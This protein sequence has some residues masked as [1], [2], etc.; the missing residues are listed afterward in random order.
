M[1]PRIPITAQID[2]SL[3]KDIF[4]KN[5]GNNNI[6]KGVTREIIPIT[7]ERATLPIT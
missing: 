7:P 5:D 2:M 1:H 3:D 4:F 6:T